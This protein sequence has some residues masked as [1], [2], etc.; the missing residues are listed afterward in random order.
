MDGIERYFLEQK[1]ARLHD[2]QAKLA[3]KIGPQEALDLYR[4][5]AAVC[6]VGCP[7]CGEDFTKTPP[8]TNIYP[9]WMGACKERIQ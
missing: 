7:N 4:W 1:V 8:E 2:L 3:G 9:H 5:Y 6:E